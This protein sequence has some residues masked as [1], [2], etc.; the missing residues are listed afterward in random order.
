MLQF[1]LCDEV[2]LTSISLTTDVATLVQFYHDRGYL[3]TRVDKEIQLSADN[4]SASVT[5]LIV[6]GEGSQYTVGK[7][8]TEDM[9]G[10][11][12]NNF[13]SEQIAALIPIKGGDV[14]NITDIRNAKTSHHRCVWRTWTY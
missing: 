12:L 5:F 7:I 10:Q 1:L 6:E 3:E 13:S 14:L 11:P 9:Y 4:E 2:N 8:L